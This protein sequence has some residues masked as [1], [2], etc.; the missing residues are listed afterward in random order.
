[1]DVGLMKGREGRVHVD[2]KRG[3]QIEREIMEAKEKEKMYKQIPNLFIHSAY[4]SISLLLW[5][6]LHLFYSL[7]CLSTSHT[8]NIHAYSSLFCSIHNTPNTPKFK[9]NILFL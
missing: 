4:N 8:I 2:P 9:L 5:S 1:M 3:R 7:F 6:Y